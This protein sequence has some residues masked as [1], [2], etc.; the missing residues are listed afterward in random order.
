MGKTTY[1]YHDY[2]KS[3]NERKKEIEEKKIL[4]R[5]PENLKRSWPKILPGEMVSPYMPYVTNLSNAV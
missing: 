4:E 5:R 2:G 3:K 1:N